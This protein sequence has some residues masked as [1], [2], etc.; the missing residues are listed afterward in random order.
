MQVA[1]VVDEP[2]EPEISQLGVERGVQHDVAGLDVAVHHALLPLL[3]K[4]E[5]SRGEAQR[6]LVPRR[7][8][9]TCCGAVQIG[10]EASVGHELVDEQ[11]FSAVMAPAHQL[12]QVPVPQPA[13]DLDLGDI[14]LPSLSRL[15]RDP[16]NC[17]IKL[18]IF[19]V[20]SVD[21]PESSL[22]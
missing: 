17:H 1:I 3:V 12:H 16:L 20:T 7:P 15:P 6:Y 21:R 10:I 5:Q 22:P 2:G 9:Q 18:Q 4:I 8:P 14:L 11:E 13:Y 19:Q